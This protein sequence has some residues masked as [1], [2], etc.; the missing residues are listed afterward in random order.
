MVAP[1][2]IGGAIAG[3]YAAKKGIDLVRNNT[4]ISGQKKRYAKE[5]FKKM[6]EGNLVSDSE[7]LDMQNKNIEAQQQAAQGQM[8]L[9]NQAARGSGPVMS[10]ALTKA[11]TNI[12]KASQDAAVRG[13]GAA[14]Q[15][16][17]RLTDI[18]RQEALGLA[19]GEQARAD[20][21]EQQAQQAAGDMARAMLPLMD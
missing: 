17:N 7:M 2:V 5:Q 6:Q 21:Q 20:T 3:T 9:L 12:A 18:R 16:R 13:A 4:G 8:A 11:S 10:G 14:I 19:A 1:L 15:E